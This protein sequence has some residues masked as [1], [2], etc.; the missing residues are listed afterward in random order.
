MK[1]VL[2]LIG[3]IFCLTTN[4]QNVYTSKK[5]ISAAKEI[6]FFGYDYSHFKL[7]EPKRYLEGE[8]KKNI[9]FWID[10]LYTKEDETFLKRKMNKDKIIFDLKYTTDVYHSLSDNNLVSLNN[11]TIEIDSIQSIINNYRAVEKEGIGLTIIVECFNKEKVS[12]SAYFTFFDISTK[13]VLMTTHYTTYNHASGLGL[14]TYWGRA[15]EG[16]VY[17]YFDGI[18]KKELRKK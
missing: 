13:K 3:V 10:Y 2:L 14:S 12:T 11:H 4:G 15:F 16:T 6:I 17:A 9:P 18:Y 7:T 5:D 8:I 1:C